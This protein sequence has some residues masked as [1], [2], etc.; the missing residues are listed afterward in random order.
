M[1]K[2]TF[3]KYKYKSL[4]Y[5]VLERRNYMAFFSGNIYSKSM[6][7]DTQL[8][9]ILPQDGRRYEGAGSPKTLILLH[10]LSDN[11]STWYRKTSI[12]RYA[13]HYDLTV[14]MPEVQRSWFQDM[15]HGH[16]MYTYITE[17]LPKIIDSLF[18]S[19]VKREDMMVAGIS[20]GGYGAIR[21]AFGRP[22]R[23]GYCGALSGAYD[24]KSLLKMSSETASV[25]EGLH[26][27]IPAIFGEGAEIPEEVSIPS[28]L[29]EAKRNGMMPKLYMMCGT[30]DFLYPSTIDIR[31]YCMDLGLDMTYEEVTGFHE[32]DIWDDAIKKMLKVFL[33]E[34]R[35]DW[36]D[37]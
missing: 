9:I 36:L 24:L 31:N 30:E 13:E 11:A 32:W 22:D 1:N 23:F 37:S 34:G 18:K 4:I 2:K 21:C 7:V 3:R 8:N 16:K 15:V 5:N 25:L 27:D 12:E 33:G 28:I 14:V 35:V 20:M 19:S 17:E 6:L 10:G 29:K 26:K